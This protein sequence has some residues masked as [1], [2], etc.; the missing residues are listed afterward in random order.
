MT[1]DGRLFCPGDSPIAPLV[2]AV[3]WLWRLGPRLEAPAPRAVGVGTAEDARPLA[4]LVTAGR[5]AGA[6]LFASGTGPA[7][8]PVPARR[9][10]AGVARFGRVRTTGTYTVFAGGDAVVRSSLGIHAVRDG[11]LLMLGA[12]AALWGRMDAFWALEA[13]AGFLIERLERPLVALPAVGCL[14]LDDF[15]GTAELQLRGAA[16]PD[17]RQRRRANAMIGRFT[18]ARARLIVAIPGRALRDGVEVPLDEVWPGAVAALT[19]GVRDG[20]LEPACHGLL[21]LD[22]R[23][24][25]EGRLDPREFATLDEAEAG[26]RIDLARAWLEARVGPPRSFVAP[27][28]G[29][30]AGALAAAD[31]RALPTWLPPAPGPLLRGSRVHETLAVGLPGVHGVDYAPLRRL[32]ALGLPPTVVFHGRLLDDRLPRLREAR[33]VVSLARLARRRDLDRIAALRGV[34]WVG[35]RELVERLRAHAAIAVEGDRFVVPDGVEAVLIE[36]GGAPPRRAAAASQRRSGN[37]SS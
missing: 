17:G 26:R 2:D 12:D 18:R 36:G 7:A 10:V 11:R 23:A 14:R 19:A 6:V 8:R 28:W 33:D 1:A 24:H 34:R 25:A 21:H 31:A 32:A 4:A 29:L 5:L 9:S 30:G 3:A 20:V 37:A 13:M 22:P 15:P 16:K 35:A 27:A